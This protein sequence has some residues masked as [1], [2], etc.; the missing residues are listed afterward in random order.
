MQKNVYSCGWYTRYSEN[1]ESLLA[2]LSSLLEVTLL[3][4]SVRLYF[5]KNL[6]PGGKLLFAKYVSIATS[7]EQLFLRAFLNCCFLRTA[8]KISL[9]YNFAELCILC[10]LCVQ[11]FNYHKV[12]LKSS[13]MLWILDFSK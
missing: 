6:I 7:A 3:K 4:I 10:V 1:M 13:E 8:V 11:V 9:F 12:I 2:V 5:S